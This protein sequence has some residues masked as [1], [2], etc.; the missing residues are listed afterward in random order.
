ML[1]LQWCLTHPEPPTPQSPTTPI[2][3]TTPFIP[4]LNPGAVPH[5]AAPYAAAPH[6]AT[7]YA[8]APANTKQKVAAKNIPQPR[9]QAPK[10]EA[11]GLVTTASNPAPTKQ[12]GV[13]DNKNDERKRQDVAQRMPRVNEELLG[14][15]AP[16][17]I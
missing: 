6:G 3:N 2:P 16:V 9:Q 11:K 17:K 10:V 13:A 14:E 4:N 1:T 7:P 8:A 5:G 12:K 15:V